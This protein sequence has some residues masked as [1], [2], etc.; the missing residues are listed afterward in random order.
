MENNFKTL[1]NIQPKEISNH[2]PKDIKFEIIGNEFTKIA[3]ITSVGDHELEDWLAKNNDFVDEIYEKNR[4]ILFRKFNGFSS[5]KEFSSIVYNLSTGGALDYAEPSSPRTRL[6]DKIY[7]STEYPKEQS[8]PQHNEHSYSKSWPKKLFFYCERPSEVGGCTPICNSSAVYNKIPSEITKRFEDKGGVMYV[9]NF[10]EE[11]DIPWETFFGTKEI[12]EVEKYCKEHH[13]NLSQI[14]QNRLRIDYVAQATLLDKPTNKKIWFNQAHL[15]H[16][17]NLDSDVYNYLIDTYGIDNLPRNSYYGDGTTIS[18]SD[19]QLIRQ[20]YEDVAFRFDWE[21]GDLLM[22]DNINFTH[23]RDPY[24]GARQLYVSMSEEDGVH[25]YLKAAATTKVTEARKNT[26][27]FF[28]INESKYGDSKAM[29]K[30]K[31]AL[32]CRMLRSLQLD[33]GSISGHISM[34]VP[35]EKNLFWVNP[36]GILFDEIT[37]DNLILVNN[38]GEVLEGDYP[39]NV[40]GF[41]IHSEIHNTSR[42]ANCIVHTH[43]PWGTLFSSLEKPEILMLDQNSCMFYDNYVLYNEFDGPVN[44]TDRAIK[45]AEKLRDKNIA[46]LAN[47]GAISCGESIETAMMY[48]ISLERSFRLNVLARQMNE[49]VNLIDSKTAQ[50][51]KEWISNPMGFKIEF[52]AL[53]RRIEREY[54]D[55]KNYYPISLSI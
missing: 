24:D 54:P 23:G 21:Q 26:A 18:I 11:M 13:M 34:K 29:L 12:K 2:Y 47:H 41:C 4:I 43:S 22:M 49:K 50:N 33:E 51:S 8:I 6:E 35:N 40:A 15:F 20:A 1:I 38:D 19:L 5:K 3:V 7:T 36:F 53:A 27:S 48:M 16:Y 30:Y 39:I 44:T 25:N 10:S 28:I 32:S 52:D 14:D 45:L 46:V 9:R 31:L 17:S 42:E 55:I 37:P